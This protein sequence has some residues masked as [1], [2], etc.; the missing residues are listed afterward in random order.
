MLWKLNKI[1]NR[2][3]IK[4]K[5]IKKN[6]TKYKA[7]KKEHDKKKWCKVMWQKTLKLMILIT[8]FIN[9]FFNLN[10]DLYNYYKL[11]YIILLQ[12]KIQLTKWSQDKAFKIKATTKFQTYFYIIFNRPSRTAKCFKILP[13]AHKIFWD[14]QIN[15]MIKQTFFLCLLR[16]TRKFNRHS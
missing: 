3:A 13:D 4:S 10:T 11:H 8:Y 7:D 15:K 16:N 6:V 2:Q 5:V 14:S 9:S 12:K 1:K